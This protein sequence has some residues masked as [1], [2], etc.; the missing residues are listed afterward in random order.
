MN[1]LIVRCRHSHFKKNG[2][3]SVQGNLDEAVP[4]GKRKHK[5]PS[6][7]LYAFTYRNHLLRLRQKRILWNL[8]GREGWYHRHTPALRAG[9]PTSLLLSHRSVRVQR[10]LRRQRRHV[11]LHFGTLACV[12]LSSVQVLDQCRVPNSRSY[13]GWLLGS[14]LNV[15][16]LRF[17]SWATKWVRNRFSFVA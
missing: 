16:P 15:I 11:Q 3:T 1:F 7:R 13:N 17:I 10:P 6:Q 9:P 4:E 12:T 2:N 14:A 5:L 8:T